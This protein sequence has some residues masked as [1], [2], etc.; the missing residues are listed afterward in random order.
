MA[1]ADIRAS[2][3]E[4][5]AVAGPMVLGP[6]EFFPGAG[7]EDIGIEMT[8]HSDFPKSFPGTLPDTNHLPELLRRYPQPIS[9]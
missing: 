5:Q 9:T 6:L 7:I 4:I 2:D 3:R 8:A 1:N